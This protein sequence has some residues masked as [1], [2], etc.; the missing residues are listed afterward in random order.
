MVN[1][2]RQGRQSAIVGAF[3]AARWPRCRVQVLRSL[4]GVVPR[5]TQAMAMASMLSRPAYTW[6]MHNLDDLIHL[7]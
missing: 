2:I 5:Q 3:Q 4:L 1:D 7:R 6:L